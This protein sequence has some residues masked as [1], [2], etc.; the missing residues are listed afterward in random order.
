MGEPGCDMNP[1]FGPS[2]LVDVLVVDDDEAVRESLA[3]IIS[4]A[5]YLTATACDGLEAFEIL[6]A[7]IV[8]A[9]V[10]DV[11]M[12]R[13]DGLALLDMLDEPP[14]VILLTAATVEGADPTM[15]KVMWYLQKPVPPAHLLD[16]VASAIGPG[17]RR[18]FRARP[19][20]LPPASALG[21]PGPRR[22]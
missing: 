21:S 17:S 11:R 13:L 22:S 10:L 2:T 6:S 19:I 5:G 1:G 12:P 18:P 16:L 9:M 14:P 15:S 7:T 20:V 4:M 8:R 3:E